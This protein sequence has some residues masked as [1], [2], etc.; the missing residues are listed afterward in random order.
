ME[1]VTLIKKKMVIG[2][3]RK[4][5]YENKKV[6]SYLKSLKWT[7]YEYEKE[8]KVPTSRLPLFNALLA[9]YKVAKIKANSPFKSDCWIVFIIKDQTQYFAFNPWRG[10]EPYHIK[11][12]QLEKL[13]GREE[14]LIDPRLLFGLLTNIY[15]WDNAYIGSLYE[16]KRVPDI[17]RPDL[18][19][20]LNWLHI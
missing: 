2:R 10:I 16:V 1:E 19:R 5:A 12:E 9:A 18:I 13:E 7:G 20:W 6:S 11:Y 15:K 4:T 8:I 14:I 3:E 17:Y